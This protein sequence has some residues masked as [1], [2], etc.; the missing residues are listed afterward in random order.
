MS[1]CNQAG[2]TDVAFNHLEGIHTLNVSNCDQ[3]GI[4]P[5]LRDRL[6]ATVRNLITLFQTHETTV[7]AFCRAL[8][9]KHGTALD[10]TLTSRHAPEPAAFICH[11]HRRDR[12]AFA[13]RL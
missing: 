3:A 13:P 11:G 2:I 12:Q 4:T 7:S 10:D 8:V 6:R 1:Y 9:P 5:A